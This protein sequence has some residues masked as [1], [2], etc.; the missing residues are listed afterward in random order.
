MGTIKVIDTHTLLENADAAGVVAALGLPYEEY[1][2]DVRVLNIFRD[3]RHLGS[4][5]FR[6]ARLTDWADS[7]Y[8]GKDLIDYVRQA[9]GIGFHDACEFIAKVSGFDLESVQSEK[10]RADL[11]TAEQKKLELANMKGRNDR[12][13]RL[14]S[15]DGSAMPEP[16]FRHCKRWSDAPV[17]AVIDTCD[18]SKADAQEMA[19]LQRGRVFHIDEFDLRINDR[20]QNSPELSK[21]YGIYLDAVQDGSY[22]ERDY[23]V[24]TGQAWEPTLTQLQM[25]DPEAYSFLIVGK[26]KEKLRELAE[27]E[28]AA[29]SIIDEKLYEEEID[30]INALREAI[31]SI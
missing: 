5:Y 18:C 24:V 6:N 3:D 4:C 9:E 17:V 16:E 29:E 13:A 19:R 20:Q 31:L 11:E 1:K 10:N 23:W 25:E 30:E 15:L 28:Q 8:N 21:R 26:K 7:S 22:P 2:G 12:I 27:R 14:L